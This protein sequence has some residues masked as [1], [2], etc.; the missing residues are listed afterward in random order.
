MVA[1][2]NKQKGLQTRRFAFERSLCSSS[3]ECCCAKAKIV[4]DPDGINREECFQGGGLYWK[5]A[6]GEGEQSCPKRSQKR[7]GCA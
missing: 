6:C 2:S 3:A 1:K 7:Y 5:I 4:Q